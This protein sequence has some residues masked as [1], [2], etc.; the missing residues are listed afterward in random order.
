MNRIQ[1]EEKLKEK[2]LF[3]F[4]PREF[5]DVLGIPFKT[6]SVF[7][8]RNLK[9]GLFVKLR[10]NY[11]MLK[12]SYPPLYAI[13]NRLYQPSYISLETA[14]SYYG[15]IPETV[16]TVT[17]VTTKPTREFK[18]P[19]AVFS[20]QRIKKSVFTGYGPVFIEGQVVLLAEAEKALADYLY[21]VDLEKTSLNDRLNL[22]NIRK[23]KL[24]TFIGAFERESLKK[25]AKE[26]YA[27]QRQPRKIY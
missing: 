7:I 1:V 5:C 4:S 19:R 17:S 14:L 13:A 15:I 21:F 24:L 27:Q 10:N 6:G 16:Y 25:K 12:D 18:T 3:V 26:M 23:N 11:Y 22:K 8:S 20:Y 9:S 2:G